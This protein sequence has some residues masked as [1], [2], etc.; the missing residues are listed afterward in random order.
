MSEYQKPYTTM[1]NAATDALEA[2]EEMNVGQAREILR[3]AQQEAEEL[4]I[5]EG[6]REETAQ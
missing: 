5:S 2:L 6:E 4:F 1:F 3:Q